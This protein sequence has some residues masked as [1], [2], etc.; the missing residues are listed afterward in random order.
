MGIGSAV[1]LALAEEGA[2]VSVFDR[3]ADAAA[4]VAE[5]IVKSGGSAVAIVGS[6]ADDSDAARAVAET[7]RAHGRL[8]LLVNN[9]GVVVYGE[10]PEFA[11]EDW[12]LVVGTN[13]KGQFLV[14][15]HAIP[16]MRRHG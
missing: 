14:A 7:V 6:V 9:A 13:L 11:E 5:E 16:E 12:D 4:R 8:D 10:V 15:K 2:A 1:C 3:D